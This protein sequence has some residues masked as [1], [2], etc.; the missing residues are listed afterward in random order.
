M[1]RAAPLAQI[2]Q[3]APTRW[4]RRPLIVKRRCGASHATVITPAVR[5]AESPVLAE[6]FS[7]LC[8]LASCAAGRLV[9]PVKAGIWWALWWRAGGCDTH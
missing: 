8:L 7:L 6:V 2:A 5:Y 3:T 9:L 4:L 1:S